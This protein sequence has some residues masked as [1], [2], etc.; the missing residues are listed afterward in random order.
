MEPARIYRFIDPDQNIITYNFDPSL[1]DE[2][3]E[4]VVTLE[5]LSRKAEPEDEDD[6]FFAEPKP[7]QEFY[8]YE[9][10]DGGDVRYQYDPGSRNGKDYVVA[11]HRTPEN[12]RRLVVEN[13]Q[14][15]GWGRKEARREKKAQDVPK[16]APHA[17]RPEVPRDA[18]M[19]DVE[20]ERRKRDSVVDPYEP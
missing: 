9:A 3:G 17:P 19:P 7:G 13:L 15:K 12:W 4:G 16:D 6:V 14:V 10:E 18:T 5:R 8:R 2:D 20:K 11:I 1:R